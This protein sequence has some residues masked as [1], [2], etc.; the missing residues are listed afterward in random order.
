MTATKLDLNY[1]YQRWNYLKQHKTFQESSVKAIFRT[2][3]WSIHCLLGIPAIINLPR[4]NC[5]FFLPPRF[6]RA[7]STG[8]FVTREN[9]DPELIYLENLLAPGDVFIDGGANFGIYTVVAAKLVG[10]S[11]KVFSFE[12]AVESYPILEKNIEINNFINTKAFQLGLSDHLGKAKFYHIDNA[13]NSYSLGAKSQQDTDFEE[14]ALTT[15]DHLVIQENIQRLDLI[16]LDVEGAEELVLRGA[17]I[18]IEK[19][20]P[21]ILFEI[22]ATALNRINLTQDG[23]HEFFQG[24]K[25]SFFAV[26]QNGKLNKLN[27]PGRGNNIAIPNEQIQSI[28]AKQSN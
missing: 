23:V 16:K 5:S 19:F 2:G 8:V 28:L 4:W 12:P 3:L 22:S 18:A 7:G 17:K 1:F 13:P 9:Y 11:G 14:I 15:I 21:K 24:L 10:N 27:V 25:Y 20:R 26:Q 6:R